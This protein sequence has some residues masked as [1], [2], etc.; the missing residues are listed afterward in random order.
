MNKFFCL[1]SLSICLLMNSVLAENVKAVVGE[2]MVDNVGKMITKDVTSNSTLFIKLNLQAQEQANKALK[3]LCEYKVLSEGDADKSTK[4]A[5]AVKYVNSAM[6]MDKDNPDY[7]FLAA[8]IYRT[9]G[10]VS[11]AKKHFRKACLILENRLTDVPMATNTYLEYAIALINGDTRYWEEYETYRKQGEDLAQKGL[12]M[13]PDDTGSPE[14]LYQRALFKLLLGDWIGG[15]KDFE[16]L[17]QINP[18]EWYLKY[19]EEYQHALEC[20]TKQAEGLKTED[21]KQ[22]LWQDGI[23]EYLTWY[24]YDTSKHISIDYSR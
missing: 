19:Y 17:T 5:E 21:E 10:G 4:Y 13:L 1:L 18:P 24:L 7:Y 11:M 15:D 22:I 9:K 23:N 2:S 12:A 16:L 20:I 8:R 14:L 6:D 3:A